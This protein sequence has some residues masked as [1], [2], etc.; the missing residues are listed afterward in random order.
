MNAVKEAL[1]QANLS[2]TS[3]YLKKIDA[4]T[5]AVTLRAVNADARER[6]AKRA[7]TEE[8]KKE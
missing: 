8:E 5:R 6:M 2:S 4:K 7:R 3:H 1:A